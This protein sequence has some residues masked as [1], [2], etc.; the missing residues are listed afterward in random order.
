MVNR[1]SFANS[2]GALMALVG[3]AIGL[4]NLWR[5]PYL[6][7]TN[8][9]AAFIIIYIAFVFLFCIPI[10]IAE[11]TIGQRSQSNAFGA[12][13]I[14]APGTK[15]RFMGILFVLGAVMVLS[16]YSVVGG[17][18]MDYLFQAISL[19]LPSISDAPNTFSKVISSEYRSLIS[20]FV[21]LLSTSVILFAGVKGGIE[22][23]AKVM[24]PLLFLLIIVVIFKSL[25]LKGSSE[26]IEFLLKPD[27]SAITANT[28]LSALG[29]AFFSLSI[30]MG[31]LMTYAS[32]VRKNKNVTALL[33]KMAIA[34]TLFALLAGLAI[35]PAVFALGV[36]PSE[37]PGLL[38]IILPEVFSQISGGSFFAI[39]F[40]AAVFLAAITSSISLL[41]VAVAFIGEEFK[42][43]RKKAIIVSS[44]FCLVLAVLC[45]L[46]QGVLSSFKLFGKTIFDLFDSTTANFIMPI[47]ALLIVI[48]VGW[49]MKK[50]EFYD[51]IST[52]KLKKVIYFIIKYIAP[53]A[54]ISI[55]VFGWIS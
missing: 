27:F 48:F 1:D 15:W 7:G 46:S 40:F 2:F 31:T 5:F 17:W 32:Y 37:G 41:E 54:I 16:F 38:F 55:M 45:S 24:M 14:L 29:Q 44:L 51:E 25:S 30:G 47:G 21:F 12:F 35:M 52:S 49:K 23:C 28:I 6:M 4:G 43:G 50:T 18:T 8:G 3:S 33:S 36:S 39:L 20:T 22:K 53:I 34:D 19:S 10:A 11:F 9:G 13:K 42:M 26:G